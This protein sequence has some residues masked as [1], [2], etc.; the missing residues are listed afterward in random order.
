MSS[1]NVQAINIRKFIQFE[2]HRT[3]LCFNSEQKKGTFFRTYGTLIRV[4]F[5]LHIL[6]KDVT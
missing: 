2:V 4:K 6:L 1:D 3:K 5:C